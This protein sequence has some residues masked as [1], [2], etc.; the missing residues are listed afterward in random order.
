[1][2]IAAFISVYIL[3]CAIKPVGASGPVV[4][5]PDLG[6][7]SLGRHIQILEDR[8][9][10]LTIDAVSG[11][12]PSRGWRDS[13][14]D[15]N[16][17][18]YTRSA[19]WVRFSVDASRIGAGSE[20]YVEIEY[21]SLDH[22]EFYRP[23]AGS[24]MKAVSG[25]SR[26]FRDRE[27]KY[28]TSV[29]RITPPT[30]RAE[31]YYARI[32]SG[33]VVE[34]PIILWSQKA[35]LE[36]V[37]DEMFYFG[38]FYGLML[39]MVLYHLFLFAGIR[40]VTYLYLVGYIFFLC[41][42][43]MSVNGI[44][45]EYI[46]KDIPSF[47]NY[48]VPLAVSIG[49]GLG[50]QFTRSFLNTRVRTPVCDGILVALLVMAAIDVIISLLFSYSISR[51]PVLLTA[52]AGSFACIA[53]GFVC[54]YRGYSE[55]RYYLVSW[56]IHL[57]GTILYIL[58]NYAMVPSNFLTHYATQIGSA[59]GVLLLSLGVADRF[60]IIRREKE[61]AQAEALRIQTD[62][63]ETL[64]RRVEER[65]VELERANELLQEND[66]IKSNFIANIS[67]EIRTPLTMILAP[68][69]S[70][71]Q[72]DTGVPDRGF[73]DSIRGNAVRLLR[74]IN[75]LLDFSRIDA[76]RM[77]LSIR[78]VDII[79]L[80]EIYADS[81]RSAAASRDIDLRLEA[82]P[83]PLQ[84]YADPDKMERII[85]N[86]L[87]N[88]LKFTGPGGS[89]VLRVRDEVSWCV[90]EVEDTG[91][92]IPPDRIDVIFDRFSQADA[93]PSRQY[94]GTGIGLSLAKEYAELQG[95]SIT[96]MSRHIADH[97]DDHGSR[98]TVK[99]PKGLRHF[100]GVNGAEILQENVADAYATVSY[101]GLM[102]VHDA[103][104]PAH[105]ED[106][107]PHG[108]T[109]CDADARVILVVEDNRDMRNFLVQLLETTY[110][111]H[112]ATNG[113]EG[114]RQA[115]S[116]RPDLIITDVMM[117]VM[118]GYEMTKRLKADGKIKNIPVLMLT[119]RAEITHRI[120]GLEQGADDYLVKPFNAKELRA[121]IGT[122]LRS[123][124][125]RD[126]IERR[127]REIEDDL[128]VALLL[129]QRLLPEKIEAMEGYES[130]AV[131]IPMDKIGG[132]FYDYT[133]RDGVIE[134]FIA[135]V[136]GHGITGALLSTVAKITLEGIQ[137]RN[138]TGAI[139]TALNEVIC[140]LTVQS[141]FITAFLGMIDTVGNTIRYSSA[142]HMAPILH[143]RSN[144]EIIELLSSGR[145][146][147]LFRPIQFEE[148]RAQ[149]QSGDRLVLYTDGIIECRDRDGRFFGDVGF[150]DFIRENG[151]LSPEEFCGSLIQRLRLFSGS[152][153]FD[154]DITL[155]V[156]DVL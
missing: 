6:R 77:T 40:D 100:E 101:R 47:S 75:N 129:Q 105:D 86:L 54:L 124:E 43:L 78:A 87:S 104:L 85:M 120:E 91:A 22:V 8:G 45:F 110:V 81:A 145:P 94:E 115:R 33:S 44:G 15:V 18:G 134:L 38:L 12:G 139:L 103:I 140:R 80:M 61:Q 132:D 20:W 88:A 35:F 50:N 36:K 119:A 126:V 24:F 106:A 74:L 136:S 153:T 63:T 73:F 117:P 107:R 21:P 128:E 84:A 102:E 92:G 96:V 141:K 99:I 70:Y 150:L 79:G 147:G 19:Y 122:L 10:A 111:I 31:T 67:H 146:L 138:E 25:D 23:H 143:R 30:N 144:G 93:G 46:W 133:V 41:M 32:Q 53:T 17:F 71:L 76:G 108:A 60:S 68:V 123:A 42:F 118:D 34:L 49:F 1:M 26:P 65:T 9:G 131:Y 3:V 95:G 125:Y 121:R 82:P 142:G 59:V 29:F 13:T 16:N 57:L 130:H 39:V 135:D 52:I 58:K 137:P 109:N 148:R 27:V 97:P 5:Q 152:D 37:N 154:D 114:L 72:G 7:Y 66:R 156:F 83:G 127:N 155:F 55:A 62:A 2:K 116:I 112:E 98:F 4:I 28:R 14:R 69:E 89:I 11:I 48:A 149:L 51:Y 151:A 113:E 64:E 56:L 90:I